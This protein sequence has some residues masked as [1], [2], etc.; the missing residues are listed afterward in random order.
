[1]GGKEMPLHIYPNTK[2][3]EFGSRD[4][5][6][7][8]D[9]T[10]GDFQIR[11]LNASCDNGVDTAGEKS[12]WEMEFNFVTAQHLMSC[13]SQIVMNGPGKAEITSGI[14]FDFADVTE[15]YDVVVNQMIDM[16]RAMREI[17]ETRW[18]LTEKGKEEVNPEY[19]VVGEKSIT[20]ISIAVNRP[21]V[22]EK[23]DYFDAVAWG[24]TAELIGDHF[25]KG[26][27]IGITG[28]LTQERWEKD[29]QKRSKVVVQIS[30]IDFL[31]P[32]EKE[33][34]IEN[35]EFAKLGREVVS[36]DEIQY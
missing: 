34:K 29:G 25:R 3:I 20:K 18:V 17:E 26:H 32:K 5:G 35:D 11:G 33:A 9:A 36:G 27:K 1:M 10:K 7:R 16:Y 21:M 13:I 2:I 12:L 31:T 24:K 14:W 22:K 6:I 19:K 8:Y 28:I 15:A 30:S 4:I 23:T